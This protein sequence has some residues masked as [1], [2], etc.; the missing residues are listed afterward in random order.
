MGKF[1]KITTL[2]GN[3]RTLLNYIG[4]K[5]IK[6]YLSENQGY[7]SAIQ[8]YEDILID[9][10]DEQDRKLNIYKEENQRFKNIKKN[11]IKK[12]KNILKKKKN[13]EASNTNEM[14]MTE[15]KLNIKNN[16]KDDK[17]F[18][19][20]NTN[21]TTNFEILESK[22]EINK[23][24]LYNPYN[25]LIH[26]IELK[27]ML[28]L[29]SCNAVLTQ[30][31][32]YY[33]KDNR[34]NYNLFNGKIPLN[35]DKIENF[36]F[37]SNLVKRIYNKNL[38]SK[39]LNNFMN[40]YAFT[41]LSGSE[42]LWMPAMF[43]L[44]G[45]N[46]AKV[47]IET[48]AYKKI[49]YEHTEEQVYR[50]NDNGTCLYD[51]LINYFE[52]NLK[53]WNAK[54]IYN[55]LKKNEKYKKGYTID[56]IKSL[57]TDIGG[58]SI[59]IKDLITGET[60]TIGASSG[61]RF[62][63]K[64]INTRFN[65]LDL[66]LCEE[67][68]YKEIEFEKYNEIKEEIPFYVEKYGVLY[69]LDKNY[70][71][72]P[73][74]FKITFNEWQDQYKISN[75]KINENCDALKLIDKYNYGMH[76]FFNN[77]SNN[78]NDYEEHDLSKAYYNYSDIKYN[79]YY[80]G[81]PSGAFLNCK[82]NNDFTK[83]DF[84]KQ[85][86]NN[87][88]GFY[89]VRIKKHLKKID[90][91]LGLLLDSEHVFYSCT[92]K[93]LLDYIELEFLNYSISPAIHVPFNEKFLQKENNISFYS[94]A[95]GLLNCQDNQPDIK[96]KAL[97]DD[98]QF[99]K[100]FFNNNYDVYYNNDSNIYEVKIDRELKTNR[101]LFYGIHAYTNTLILSELLNT[102]LNN[103]L[104][105]KLDSI[106]S[107]KGKF[108]P[109]EKTIF[110]VKKAKLELM[111]KSDI[112]I[113]PFIEQTIDLTNDFDYDSDDDNDD[114]NDINVN[115]NFKNNTI[116]GEHVKNNII[117]LGGAGG[118]GKSTTVLENLGFD[119]NDMV[120]T[121]SSWD[122]I[123]RKMTEYNGLLGLSINKLV[124]KNCK[125]EQI[126][127][128][129]IVV[130]EMTLL[131]KK[132]IEILINLNKDKYIFLLGD[133][134]KDGFFYQCSVTNNIY[135]PNKNCQ[136]IK[137]LK[138]YRFNENLNNKLMLIRDLMKQKIDIKKL[139]NK[140]KDLFKSRIFKKNNIIYNDN[141]IGIAPKDD[142]KNN[143]V[144]TNYFIDK[145]AK[146]R[147][148]IKTTYLQK[149]EF[150]GREVDEN[151]IKKNNNYEKKLFKTIHSFQGQ[152][153]NQDQKII[154]NINDLFDYNLLYT[155]LSRARFEEQIILFLN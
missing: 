113:S 22:I 50:N 117:Y 135:V 30:Q 149:N 133:V 41:Y 121:S 137:L 17:K 105:V 69:T 72:I 79:K 39:I 11:I 101:H 130:D 53:N 2:S 99:Y 141:D 112:N 51:G 66:Y 70:K 122:L 94:K 25:D 144:L 107:K 132:D 143:S 97:D 152:Q 16:K 136:Y 71:V 56:E 75:Q 76:R 102:D 146:P 91:R 110:K 126:N 88:V 44:W 129:I 142:L 108:K 65:H 59:N 118:T 23:T 95:C 154:I 106:V 67:E 148:Y 48:T 37:N 73:T 127:K 96:I 9:Y 81:L 86:N 83:I 120:F 8:A 20:L 138:N 90:D 61:N 92:I 28:K 34:G 27:K 140:V 150:R 1:S 84:I 98:K 131:D 82:C 18:N 111:F 10:N 14:L 64:F 115:I 85:I 103:I 153:L 54:K 74:N 45:G 46:N 4:Y 55:L 40:S 68:E 29:V 31:I 109:I 124:G 104:G 119:I 78:E 80:V 89:N 62:K 38:S 26:K 123:Q 139:S 19:K 32:K 125:K 100:T 3:K 128:K 52:K 15:S 35:I 58:F 49:E 134:D 155:A 63:I 57:C 147:Y 12:T 33:L 6:K 21:D 114:D 5:S 87:I 151:F 93:L 13:L 7:D 145:G 36:Y 116:N 47:V 43:L 42:G 60:T 24:N 77:Y